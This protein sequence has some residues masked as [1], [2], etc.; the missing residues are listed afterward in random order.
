MKPFTMHAVL[1]YRHQL[2]DVA[3]Q[4][5]HQALEVEAR[6]Q[7]TL[8][9]A[10]SELTELYSGLEQDKNQGT[11]VD[12]LLLFDNRIELVKQQVEL[13]RN[14]LEKQQVQVANKRQQLVKAS[15]GRKIMGKLQEQ[16]NAA[17]AKYLEKKELG[18]LDEI[19]VLSHER[20]HR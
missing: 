15:K 19:A 2:E 14:D 7:E 1:K 20:K 12:R 10:E 13:R 3:L 8:V 11:T 4:S 17:Y 9:Q 5:L 6:L 18:M 16:Q